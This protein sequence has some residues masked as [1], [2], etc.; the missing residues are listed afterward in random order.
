M[1][2]KSFKDRI[3]MSQ[4]AQLP[5]TLDVLVFNTVADSDIYSWLTQECICVLWAKRRRRINSISLHGVF[6]GMYPSDFPTCRSEGTQ[7]DRTEH[8]FSYK[9]AGQGSVSLKLH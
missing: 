4:R 8:K 3:G 9:Q 2:G 1:S 5:K 7:G 6:I